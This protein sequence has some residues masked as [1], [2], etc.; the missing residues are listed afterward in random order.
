[1]LTQSDTGGERASA[2]LSAVGGSLGGRGEAYHTD[3][4]AEG[5]L[6]MRARRV[7]LLALESMGS[8]MTDDVCVPRTR[9]ADLIT[10]CERIAEEVG[11]TVAVVGHAGDGNMHPTVVYDASSEGEFE[12]AKRAFDA[13]LSWGC[14]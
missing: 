10:G 3:D 1:M 7:T 6:L 12:R 13:I 2:E 14:P 9:I 4:L 5:D 11:L 8:C